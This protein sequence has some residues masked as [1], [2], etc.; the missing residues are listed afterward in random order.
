[1]L[2]LTALHIFAM[3]LTHYVITRERRLKDKTPIMTMVF[4]KAPPN[5]CTRCKE[6]DVVMAIEKGKDRV[7]SYQKVAA[8]TKFEFP[9]VSTLKP[10]NSC[11]SK[12]HYEALC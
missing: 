3:A 1:M 5:H 10:H 9:V 6:E 12:S 8:R 4:K 7:L 2:P 11:T